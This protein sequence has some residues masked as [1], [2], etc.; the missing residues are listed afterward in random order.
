MAKGRFSQPRQPR[1]EEDDFAAVMRARK[2]A[3]AA[4]QPA[5]P[6]IPAA[7]APQRDPSLD[8]TLFLSETMIAKEF[9]PQNTE[10]SFEETQFLSETADVPP[11]AS[12]RNTEMYDEEYDEDEDYEDSSRGRGRKGLIIAICV[13]AAL[14]LAAI[15]GGVMLFLSAN[16]DDGLILSNVSVAGINIGGMTPEEAKSAIHR[17]T[18]LTYSNED[19]VVE[20]P[21]TTLLLSPADTGVK[22]DVD[23]V[24][25]A[26]YN[27]GR[28]GTK[29]ENKKAKEEAAISTHTIALLSYLELDTEYIRQ[30]LDEYG[31][32][33][34][35]TYIAS[36]YTL[37]GEM[38]QLEGEEFDENAV[39][40]TLILDPGMPGRN[41]DLDKVYND[42][43]DAYSLN[44]FHVEAEMS[45]PEEI[46]EEL[47]LDAIFEELHVDPVD[48]SMDMETFEVTP[49]TYGYTFDLEKAKELLAETVY[50]DTIGIPMEYVTPE[51]LS[52]DL[53]GKLFRDVLASY[54][55]NHTN[56]SN[57]NH[58][59]KLACKSLNG[60]VLNPGDTFDYNKTLGK[61]TEAAGYKEAGALM[62]GETIKE[63]GG[64]ICQVSST[65]YYCTLIA[66]LEI[67]ERHSHSL[68]SSYMPIM[69]TDATVSWGGP[70]FRFKNNTDFPI[71]IEAEVS[72]GKVKIKLL[73]TDERDY[74][75]KMERKIV[76]VLEPETEYK[77]FTAKEAKAKG[78]RDGQILEYGTKGYTVYTYR[79][80][81]DMETD[82]LISKDYEAT[83]NYIRK[84]DIKVKIT[85]AETEPTT[86]PTE[87]PKPTETTP[88]ATAPKPTETTPPATAP[89]PT[90]T[91]PPATQAPPQAPP[92]T[93]APQD[94]AG[95]TQ[96]P[97]AETQAPAAEGSAA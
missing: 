77:E 33:F 49:E 44:V 78:Y 67:V 75:I 66:D 80:K 9:V 27:Y 41:L 97:A 39:C 23:A 19:M 3:Q 62:A 12:V 42:I 31:E 79:C 13:V 21:D 82:K 14:L 17:A 90:E 37:E 86:P 81:Y 1:R 29:E 30:T 24:V 63:V 87:A 26:A 56:D 34:N 50:G 47:D 93:E 95:E 57:R 92:A 51:V 28:S 76:E 38:P 96:T 68:V 89:K 52:K 43:L 85:D 2:Q 61:R 84:N 65:L 45:A 69:G 32:T 72:D 35:S 6:E 48:A 55:T 36:S 60:L 20:M 88:P 71:R 40:Q 25:E 18:D 5:E 10:P 15:V 11:A 54:E 16:A 59:L 8:E 7:P 46:P 91:T 58:N 83:S 4:E 73:G 94:A 74:Y 22:L 64:G 53:D 70:N